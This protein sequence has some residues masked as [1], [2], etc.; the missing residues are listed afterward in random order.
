MSKPSKIKLILG[1]ASP[2]RK[3][4]LEE[5]GFVFDVKTAD[6]DEKQIRN[7]N[8]RK[9]VLSLGLAKLD[10]I[11]VKNKF[12][13][14]TIVITSDLVA[15]HDGKLREKP[16]SKKEVINWHKEY[17]KGGKTMIYCSIIA[18]HVGLN[19]TL[20]SVDTASI[21]WGKIPN[22]VIEEMA[23]DPMT[24]KGAGFVS[25]AFFNYAT[26]LKGTINTVRGVPLKI[27]EEFLE[28]LGY[29]K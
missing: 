6:I 21:R 13:P 9:L 19:K 10:A 4:L 28:E 24:Y 25:R 14:N 3:K 20:K 2:F 11:L 26:S 17:Q 5:A 8:F 18:H 29:F 16:V 15:S 27:L 12:S 1:S 23:S 7:N 22:R